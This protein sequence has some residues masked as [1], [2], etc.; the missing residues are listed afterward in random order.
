MQQLNYTINISGISRDGAEAQ[1]MVGKIYREQKQYNLSVDALKS[2]QKK[3]ET[4]YEVIHKAFLVLA[5]NYVDMDNALQA[6]ATLKSVIEASKDAKVLAEA[7][8]KLAKLE[9][10]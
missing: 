5:D 8:A 6:K 7:R 3:Y 10:K 9:G 1:Y 4:F 2:V